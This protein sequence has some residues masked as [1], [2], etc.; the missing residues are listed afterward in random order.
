MKTIDTLIETM[1]FLIEKHKDVQAAIEAFFDEL[2]ATAEDKLIDTDDE[3]AA[4]N[5]I[6]EIIIQINKQAKIV[7]EHLHEVHK[8]MLANLA[9]LKAIASVEDEEK[10]AQMLNIGVDSKDIKPI[11]ET[12]QIVLDRLAEDEKVRTAICEKLKAG[13]L[14][15]NF[16]EVTKSLSLENLQGINTL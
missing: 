8:Y 1:V 15:N 12:K 7:G 3:D 10:Q 9:E 13:I 4:Y 11:E 5:S 16:A 6:E 2:L 14:N